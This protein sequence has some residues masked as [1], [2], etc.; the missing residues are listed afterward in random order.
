LDSTNLFDWGQPDWRRCHQ[1]GLLF[2]DDGAG[3]G[4]VCTRGG[5]HLVAV[6]NFD[7]PLNYVVPFNAADPPP[8]GNYWRIC[9]NCNALFYETGASRVCPAPQFGG[10]HQPTG[11]HFMPAQPPQAN[12][13]LPWQPQWRQC[14]K[15]SGLF[16]TGDDNNGS[17][18]EDGQAHA[19]STGTEFTLQHNPGADANYVHSRGQLRACTRCSGLVRA[20]QG[21]WH[22]VTSPVVV[23]NGD[24]RLLPSPTG[25][26]VVMISCDWVN[27]RLSWMPLTP[28]GP[29]FDSIRYYHKAKNKWTETVDSNPGYELFWPGTVPPQDSDVRSK[30]WE[31]HVCA[32]WLTG[33]RCWIAMY[34]HAGQV[35]NA[36]LPVVA[37]FSSD[38]YDW[39]DEVAIFDPVRDHAYGTWMH[40]PALG[41]QNYPGSRDD[42]K[43]F[44]YGAFLINDDD[45]Q[46][47]TWDPA[48]RTLNLVYVM[49]PSS[50][51]HVQLMQTA[52]QLPDPVVPVTPSMT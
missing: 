10:M 15:C 36:E 12:T 32:S 42:I 5:Q 26:G 1:C 34:T 40:D 47:T 45:K 49:S 52:L 11:W 17:C 43:G 3:S 20:D 21:I 19:A 22:P 50:P 13:D 46:F 7:L 27:F 14:T 33:P 31:P 44:A 37:R 16:Y 24:H 28:G 18:P 39:S 48:R 30:I 29:Q 4:G 8:P 9:A 25:Q 41:N 51:Y 6:N 38:L 35:P 23:N 2:W